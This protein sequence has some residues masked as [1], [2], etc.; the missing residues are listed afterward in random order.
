MAVKNKKK[1]AVA[2]KAAI[3]GEVDGFEFY[4]LLAEK[5]TNDEAKSRLEEL[6]DDEARHKEVLYDLYDLTIGGRP[7]QLPEQGINVLAKLFSRGKLDPRKSEMEI[8]DFAI[9][10]ELAAVKFY[11]AA[12]G[13]FEDPQLLALFDQLADEEHSHF[14]ILQAE[15]QAFGSN[16]HWFSADIGQPLEH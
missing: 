8:I 16:Y 10:A 5:A 7:E 6:R 4:K 15:K 9:E 13:E 11:Q 12:Q 1:L 14:E 3:K 2:L